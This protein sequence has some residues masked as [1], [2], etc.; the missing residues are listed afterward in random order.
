MKTWLLKETRKSYLPDPRWFIPAVIAYSVLMASICI[1]SPDLDAWADAIFKAEGGYKATYLY[2]IRSVKYKDEAEARRIC[3]NTVY[4]TLVK[5]RESRC[6][7]GESDIDC[8]AQRYCPV[9]S[10]TDNGT[11]QYWKRNVE[12]FLI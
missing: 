9:G 5:Y 1:A 10:D 4:N 8:L 12:S 2:G 11:C 7:V 3:K 6:K